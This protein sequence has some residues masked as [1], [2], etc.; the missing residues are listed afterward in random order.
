MRN[1]ICSIKYKSFVMAE[2]GCVLEGWVADKATEVGSSG[3]LKEPQTKTLDLISFHL[4]FFL[5][6]LL[7]PFLGL[8]RWPRGEESTS[9]CRRHRRHG[10][11]SWVGKIPLSRKWITQNQYACL[12]NSVGREG[13]CATVHVITEKSDMAEHALISFSPTQLKPIMTR[14]SSQKLTQRVFIFVGIPTTCDVLF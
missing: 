13:W 4:C 2:E 10:F 8:P 1:F 3:I 12:E 7:F 11:D 6:K 5:S 14:F 9:Q